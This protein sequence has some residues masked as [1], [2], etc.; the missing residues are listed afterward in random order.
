MVEN[1]ISEFRNFLHY[2]IQLRTI[3]VKAIKPGC[4]FISY[5]LQ[6]ATGYELLLIAFQPV[7]G[8]TSYTPF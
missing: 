2:D 5:E 4:N 1:N 7:L 8:V 3:G 6:G